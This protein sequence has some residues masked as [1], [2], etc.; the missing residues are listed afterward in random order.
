VL[1]EAAKFSADVITPLNFDGDRNPGT[2]RGGR[3]SLCRIL[4]SRQ[5]LT[6]RSGSASE[7]DRVSPFIR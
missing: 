5:K 7:T 4:G 1:D 2:L 3:I 6:L